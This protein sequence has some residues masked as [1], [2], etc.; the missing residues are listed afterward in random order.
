MIAGMLREVKCKKC[1]MR[2]FYWLGDVR[3]YR[4]E[5]PGCGFVHYVFK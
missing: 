1:K 3:P 2:Y 5:C 4:V